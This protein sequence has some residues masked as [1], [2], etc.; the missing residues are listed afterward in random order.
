MNDKER[1]KNGDRLIVKGERRPKNGK[2]LI[3]NHWS[4]AQKSLFIIRS[5]VFEI[6]LRVV[7]NIQLLVNFYYLFH[8]LLQIITN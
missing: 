2:L 1:P 7:S 8:C 3:V 4:L 6:G 5:L